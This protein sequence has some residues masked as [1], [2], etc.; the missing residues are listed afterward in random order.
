LVNA[1]TAGRF[2][3]KLET[4]DKTLHVYEDLYHEIYNELEAQRE[5]V[6]IN[7]VDWLE[8]RI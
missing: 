2:F 1:R 8:E 3:E 5:K 4:P 7:L 6:L